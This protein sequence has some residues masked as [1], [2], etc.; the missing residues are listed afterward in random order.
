MEHFT[1]QIQIHDEN[2]IESH[3]RVQKS[4][5]NSNVQTKSNI[6]VRRNALSN[7]TNTKLGGGKQQQHI[8][9][10]Q[11]API[12]SIITKENVI[13]EQGTTRSAIK[14]QASSNSI[15]NNSSVLKKSKKLEYQWEDL[16]EEDFDD[17]LMVSEYVVEIFE[18][19]YQLEEK[20]LP[21]SDY[22]SK[23]T[24]IN[25]NMRDQ[26]VDWMNEVHLKFRLLPETLF[27]ST[28]LMDR[29]LS[30]EIVQVNRLQ[31]LGTACMFIA[32]KY[33]EIYSPSVSNFANESG[34]TVEEIL[35][36][37]KFVLEIL[38]FDVSYP[39]PMN[40]LRRISKADDYDI[41]S[42]TIGKYFM[43]ISI[44]DYH[45]IGI[46]PSL[47]AAASI[48]LARKL[49][50]KD[51]WNGNLIHYSGEVFEKDLEPIVKL[52]I[53]YLIGPVV[54]E[55]FF[56]KYASRRFMKASIISRQWA[57]DLVKTGAI[58]I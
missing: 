25:G 57:K 58:T 51:D 52:Y 3:A 10:T 35:A 26:L 23:Q 38:S 36:A 48:F 40:F 43:E 5:I 56:K 49:L 14:R 42:R 31:L 55:E 1:N 37:E 22:L 47:C 20:T 2:K 4:K 46:K 45:F 30:K 7:V 11:Q 50:G 27:V 16:D 44:M 15:H 17:P 29:F 32:S 21:L 6:P 18:Y 8:K 41:H 54:H 39:N 13:E 34:S 19:L 24:F 28:N 9:Q 12:Q 33:E 53:Q